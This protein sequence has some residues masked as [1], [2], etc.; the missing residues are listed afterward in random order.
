[1]GILQPQ[2]AVD[3]RA[4]LWFPCPK[5]NP[6]ARLRFFCFPYAGVGSVAYRGWADGLPPAVEVRPVQLPGRESRLREPAYTSLTALVAVLAETIL[7][8]LD[9]PYIFYGHSLG[10]LVAFELAR[11][12]RRRQAPL[13]VHLFLSSRRASHLPDSRTPIYHLPDA[14]FT[15][16]VQRR[17]N[18]IPQI[19]LQ[20]A[21]LMALFLPTLKADFSI[22]ETYRYRDEPPF[23]FPISVFGGAQDPIVSA[24]ELAAWRLHTA[25]AFTQLM[26]PGDHF[27]LQ[28][29]RS[30]LLSAISKELNRYLWP[31]QG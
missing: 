29:Q 30:L 10:A 14:A 9:R 17:Y 12:L 22:L 28:S 5:P 7:S 8:L 23:D 21:E 4:D 1:M 27:F 6:E 26:F 20:D 16:E 3:R 18:G 31:G 2:I 19:I 25:Q 15:V 13:P 11:Q 24:E